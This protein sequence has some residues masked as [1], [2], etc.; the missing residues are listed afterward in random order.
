LMDFLRIT[1]LATLANHGI[2]LGFR[3]SNGLTRHIG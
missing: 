3:V 1:L 2:E